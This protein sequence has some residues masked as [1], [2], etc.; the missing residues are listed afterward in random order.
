MIVDGYGDETVDE[1]FSVDIDPDL[2][3]VQTYDIDGNV[4]E[5]KQTFISP[6]D[7]IDISHDHW[8]LEYNGRKYDIN[9]LQPR[10]DIGTNNLDHIR[11]ILR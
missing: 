3:K 6:H 8:E 11:A 4:V 7:S 9:E 2:G 10:H 5:G 1:S